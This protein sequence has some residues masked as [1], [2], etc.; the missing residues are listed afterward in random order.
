M[1]GFKDTELIILSACLLI[2]LF[3][4]INI[5]RRPESWGIPLPVNK[6]YYL[7]GL[8]PLAGFFIFLLFDRTE[9]MS[10]PTGVAIQSEVI[11]VKGLRENVRERTEDDV[12]ISFFVPKL[13]LFNKQTG[14]LIKNIS[15]FT[16]LYLT[17]TR[18]IGYGDIGYEVIELTTG[19][20]IEKL[21]EKDLKQRAAALGVNVYS[22]EIKIGD[23]AFRLRSV[24]DDIYA[25]DPLENK[26]SATSSLY[27]F[28]TSNFSIPSNLENLFQAKVLQQ[29]PNGTNVIVSYEDLNKDYFLLHGYK[30]SGEQL[31]TKK[32][33]EI[34]SKISGSEF[35]NDEAESNTAID[36]ESFYFATKNYLVCMDIQ[37]GKT[38]WITDF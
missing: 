2:G 28:S 35:V 23:N 16:P 17:G 33:F 11:I 9:G 12:A 29:L 8:V 22:L 18:M 26:V 20:I 36:S 32:D 27:P 14:E 31:W 37:T 24:K 15:G 1:L 30:S 10:Y 5:Y 38:K 13:S 34:S 25:F 21:T 7:L 19:E 4:I 6:L 3:V